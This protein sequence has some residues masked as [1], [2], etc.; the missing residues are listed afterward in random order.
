M[1]NILFCCLDHKLKFAEERTKIQSYLD[2]K[3]S[4]LFNTLLFLIFS[5]VSLFF[6]Y[7]KDKDDFYAVILFYV[8][9][10][11]LILFCGLK[12]SNKVEK[13][14]KPRRN[15]TGLIPE[16][17]I[18]FYSSIFKLNVLFM[19]FMFVGLFVS[20]LLNY[21]H[22]MDINYIDIYIVFTRIMCPVYIIWIIAT[23]MYMEA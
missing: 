15:M 8:I 20:F 5:C 22:G 17:I 13:N 21:L 14:F 16:K 10:N 3:T 4:Y 19:S 6:L 18:I 12:A 11:V 9:S 23:L 2:L 7:D 1:L